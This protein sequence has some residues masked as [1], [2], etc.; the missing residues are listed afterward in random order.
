VK[1]EKD[2]N[3]PWRLRARV[4]IAAPEQRFDATDGPPSVE[5]LWNASAAFSA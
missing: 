5:V 3:L 4:L 2:R 1:P